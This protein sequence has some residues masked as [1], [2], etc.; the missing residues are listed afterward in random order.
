ME[1]LLEKTAFAAGITAVI[2][3][4]LFLLFDKRIDL[5]VHH[6]WA[7]TRVFGLATSISYAA[8]GPFIKLA[9]A[10]CLILIVAV[11]PGMERR[12]TRGL[13][14]I[15]VSCSMAIILGEGLKYLLGR[16]RPI[17]LL[18]HEQ[19]GLKFFSSEWAVNS[20]PSGHTLRAFSI[21]TALS[22]LFRRFTPLFIFM[23]LLVGASRVFVTAHYPSDVVFGAFIGIFSAIWTSHYFFGPGNK[24]SK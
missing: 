16:H 1:R 14:Y 8:T 18:E 20:S 12:W 7:N 19:Y 4:I 5:W 10:I 24:R 13:L 23:A 11:D 9:I 22:L 21:L 2:Y 17:M 15:C 3:L 6:T